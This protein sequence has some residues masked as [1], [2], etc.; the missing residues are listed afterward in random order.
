M[1]S[2]PTEEFVDCNE[3][4]KETESYNSEAFDSEDFDSSGSDSEDTNETYYFDSSE[5]GSEDDSDCE[6]DM[7]CC[8]C[9]TWL[10]IVNLDKS[11]TK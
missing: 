2:N 7:V 9:P 11:K 3:S 6:I 8:C 1:S 4:E 5:S 10:K